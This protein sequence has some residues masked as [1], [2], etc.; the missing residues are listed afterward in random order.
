MRDPDLVGE[1][2]ERLHE[3]RKGLYQSAVNNSG[4]SDTELQKKLDEADWIYDPVTASKDA[5]THS[6]PKNA[7]PHWVRCDF[8]RDGV[9][10]VKG[11]GHEKGYGEHA[12]HEG[13]KT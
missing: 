7:P 5:R 6:R 13:P 9:R 4:L 12:K 3:T 8:V 11:E 2:A 10:C 1:L